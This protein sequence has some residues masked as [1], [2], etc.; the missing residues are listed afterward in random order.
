MCLDDQVWIEDALFAAS[1]APLLTSHPRSFTCR[2]I[3]RMTYKTYLSRIGEIMFSITVVRGAT[4]TKHKQNLFFN[5]RAASSKEFFFPLVFFWLVFLRRFNFISIR[6][7]KRERERWRDGESE[8]ERERE[9][10]R[11]ILTI[12]RLTPTW[13]IGLGDGFGVE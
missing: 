11:E 6:R 1:P 2:H 13:W 7:G 5:Y 4:R 10:E 9:R 12:I 3:P 8:R